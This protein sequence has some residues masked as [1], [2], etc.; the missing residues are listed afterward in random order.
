MKV[1]SL[2]I[3][4]EEEY[5]VVD[6]QTGELRS[7]IT[8]IL[9]EDHRVLREFDFKPKLRQSIIEIGT[10]VCRTAAEAGE[11]LVKIRRS[12]ANLSAQ[13]GLKI[14]AAGTHP[15]SSWL[16]TDSTPIEPFAGDTF[17][18]EDLAQ[19]LLIFSTHVHITIE[20]REFLI[21]AMNVS[22]YL[23]PHVLALASSSPFWLGRETGLKSYRSSVLR[24]FPRTGIPRIFDSW[25]DYTDLVDTLMKT[26]CL[27][28]GRGIWWDVRPNWEY[29]TLEF[30]ICDVCTR[31][32]EAVCMAAIFQAIVA[33][34]WKLRYDNMTF[35]IYPADLIEE[36]KWRA[37][38]DGLDGSLIDFGKKKEL[39]AREL[40]AELVDWFI[41][42]VVDE[43]GSGN[44]VAYAHKIMESGTSAD[45]QLAV[46][47]QTGSLQAVVQQLIQETN[48][49]PG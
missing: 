27:V 26:N 44:E 1:P 47:R 43:L 13:H 20:D 11:E 6:P 38:R 45:R 12:V 39:P 30:R 17:E 28:D 33:K 18:R 41:A 4:I 3:G 48:D 2:T 16:K 8:Q 19:Q 9:E 29:P 14:V 21:D 5:Q 15:Y 25:A 46:F 35:R 31:V 36:N 34:L 10:K 7:Y 49:L 37:V 22:R 32:E 40:I 42:D 23:M 24:S